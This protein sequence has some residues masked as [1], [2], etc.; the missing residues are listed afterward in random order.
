MNSGTRG[1]YRHRDLD[2]IL[3]PARVAIVGISPSTRGA[4]ARALGQLRLLGFEGAIDLV[5]AK[6]TEI[7]GAPCH[8]SIASVGH[9]PDCVIITVPQVAVENVLLDAASAGAKSAIIFAAGYADTGR[10]DRRGQQERLAAIALDTGI[11][12]IGP[13]CLGAVN[14]ADGAALTY[15]N[16]P[17]LRI[18]D[19]IVA[20]QARAVGLVSQS[21]GLGFACAQ[22]VQRGVSLSHI[23]T[24]GNSCD[25]DVA[26]Y[27]AYLAE[28]PA[29]TAIACVFE[30]VPSGARLLEA[31]DIAFRAGKPLV[32]HK[33]G[34]GE[35]GAA[36][37]MTHS[38]M[39]A[40]THDAFVAS[41]E[42]VG[43]IMVDGFEN[44]IET[45][46]YCAKADPDAAGGVIV[47]TS[48]GGASVMAADKAELHGVELPQ[49]DENIRA[50]VQ[51]KLPDF[52]TARN[53][54]DVTGGL[55][56]DHDGYF[57]CVDLLLSDPAYGTLV[58]AHP[59]SVHTANRVRAF[60]ELAAKYD[61][62]VCNVWITEYLAGPGLI[63]AER[64]PNQM[65]FRSMDR[66]FASMAALRDWAASRVDRLGVSTGGRIVDR[67][68]AT[69]AGTLLRA[70]T[71]MILTER[72]AKA[73]LAEYGVTVVTDRL[74][75]SPEEAADAADALGYPVVVKIDSP[76][77]AHKTEAGVVAIDLADRA[78]VLA[79]ARQVLANAA[80]HAPG[81]RV[82]GL[83]VQPMIPAGVEMMIGAKRDPVFGQM[84]VVGLGGVF[85]ELLKDRALTSVPVSPAAGELL[86]ERLKGGVLLDGYRG[87]ARVDR[88][89][90]GELI[91]RVS[92]LLA[93]HGDLLDGAD[94]NPIICNGDTIVAVDALLVR[95]S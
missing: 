57:A 63:E 23:L 83:L 70:C 43:A 10:E 8:P 80:T 86:L 45:A 25:V 76:D 69:R 9:A 64:D 4:G 90:L 33:L 34:T 5:N 58:T 48:S 84:L 78:T 85:V 51:K 11:R 94:I 28:A 14:Y 73:V 3:N 38:G 71:D 16:T 88:K 65:V 62:R 93:D 79:A 40:G 95:R 55:A 87:G 22:A 91:A 19:R 82:D 20:P 72:Q 17:V 49:P 36:A 60:G 35:G 53:P 81:A 77:I 18:D 92:E 75:A 15:T 56:N 39:L 27:I 29:C 31:A 2:P 54:C 7:D 61:K 68:A 46:A 32:V 13:N 66:C 47:L 59:Y 52:G 37:A 1:V 67:E 30:A 42:Q 50:A 24:S 41:L 44:L 12:I 21:G 89:A 74:A 26:D 6:Y